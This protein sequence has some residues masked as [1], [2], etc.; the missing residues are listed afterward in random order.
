MGTS[1]AVT[2]ATVAGKGYFACQDEFLKLMLK[3]AMGVLAHSGCSLAR[4]CVSPGVAAS[5]PRQGPQLSVCRESPA[6]AAASARLSKPMEGVAMLAELLDCPVCW[7]PSLGERDMRR[8]CIT[9]TTKM[10][11]AVGH[12][13]LRATYRPM[14]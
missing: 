1:L 2:L 5:G 14:A 3:F 7:C 9:H 4:P 10:K 6:S 11:S 8:E 13:S 12:T